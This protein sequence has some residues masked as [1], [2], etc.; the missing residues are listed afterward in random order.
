MPIGSEFNLL[1]RIQSV[2]LADLD[3]IAQK[4]KQIDLSA[5]YSANSLKGFE[6][7]L[8]TLVASGQ[9]YTNALQQIARSQKT[10][11]DDAARI[12]K[13]IM[14]NDRAMQRSKEE[15]AKAAER[16]AVTEQQNANKIFQ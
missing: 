14:A 2:G 8:R 12:A 3:G 15:N 16:E 9:S 1:Y 5:H 6:A 10:L 11:G 13:D 7:I 4:N